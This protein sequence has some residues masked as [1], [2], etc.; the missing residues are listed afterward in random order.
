MN[1]YYDLLTAR[2][3][4]K[5]ISSLYLI[6]NKIVC[7]YKAKDLTDRHIQNIITGNGKTYYCETNKSKNREYAVI[8]TEKV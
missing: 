4:I 8:V 1:T 2:E 5:E 7:T 6:F 3:V